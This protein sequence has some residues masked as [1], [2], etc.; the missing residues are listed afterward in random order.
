LS[1]LISRRLG[2]EMNWMKKFVILGALSLV[3][4][5]LHAD[6]STRV[7][8]P[9]V[10]GTGEYRLGPGDVVE[11]FVWKETDLTTTAVVRPDG[12]I[13]LPLINDIDAG[14]KTAVE[15]QTAIAQR[16]Q[17]YIT[18]PVVSVILKEVNAPRISVLGNV[19]KPDLYKIQHSLTVL[20]A[21]ALA[22]GFNEYAKR[23][24]VIV[25]RNTPDGTRKFKVDLKRFIE[26]DAGQAFYL[27]QSDTIYVQ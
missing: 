21:V 17:R 25:I 2:G 15:L 9:R 1:A 22:G 3:L 7:P 13:S 12:K 14:D 8:P 26:K 5:P 27:Q 6:D 24:H 10:F 19:R 20:D 4:M 18:E 16:L 23:D 11:V